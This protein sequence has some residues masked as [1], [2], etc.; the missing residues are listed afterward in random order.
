MTRIEA[1]S[2]GIR[3]GRSILLALPDQATA[4][5]QSSAGNPRGLRVSVT[6][7]GGIGAIVG[8]GAEGITAATVFAVT[9]GRADGTAAEGGIACGIAAVGPVTRGIT[10]SGI[11][12]VQGGRG[13]DAGR[14][15]ADPV[16][17]LD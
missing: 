17:R 10:G 15:A 12:P 3:G 2:P 7:V 11:A 4:K 14:S 16:G 9:G 1:P 6:A 8:R 5:I 13:I